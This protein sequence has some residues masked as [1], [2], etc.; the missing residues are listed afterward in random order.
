MNIRNEAVL[1]TGASRGLGRELAR[2][3]ARRGARVVLVARGAEELERA[4]RE[5]R[6][7]GGEAHALAFDVGEKEAVH[8]I[9]GAAAALVGPPSIVIHNASTLGPVPMPLL[10]DTECEDLER[11]LAVNLVGPFRLTKVLAGPMVLRKRGLFLFVSSDAALS[12]YA[13]WGSYGVSKAAQDHL[14]RSFAAELDP[15]RFFAVDPGEM[16]TKM[17]ADAIPD[18][19][20][21][22]L[23]RPVD[24]AERLVAIVARSGALPN[25]ARLAAADFEPLGVHGG[26]G[27][28]A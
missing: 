13:R 22:S 7:E 4:A 9:A 17:H 6:A 25:G 2:S 15:V 14:A 28:A 23:A 5:I 1:V 26:S 24:V 18:A 21:A 20:R 16:D 3:F 8:R 12:A 19:D 10:L 27:A 11:V